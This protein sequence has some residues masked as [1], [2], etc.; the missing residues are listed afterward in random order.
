MKKLLMALLGV[1]VLIVTSL[2]AP[3][4]GASD[5]DDDGDYATYTVTFT[6][7]TSG[8][9]LTPP[10]W[11]AHSDDVE[12]FD[13]GDEASPGLQAVAEN[14]GVP[15]L[16]AELLANIDDEGEGVSGVGAAGPVAPGATVTWTFTT[17]E[18]HFSLAS[19]I[20]CTNDGFGGVDSKRLPNRDGR[21]RTY[22]VHAYDAGTEINTEL[23]ADLVPAPFCLGGEIGSPASNPAL[24]EDGEIRRHR[25]IRGVGDLD[26][27]FDWN[28]PV[29]RVSITRG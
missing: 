11:A 3:P 10:N 13:K 1:S 9:Y 12:I 24:A 8:Q 4:A 7:L 14:G 29:A 5:D 15:V 16:A 26:S 6:N 20:I 23:D 22:N 17:D 28:G 19:M 18:R 25:G 27:S 2:V 21:T